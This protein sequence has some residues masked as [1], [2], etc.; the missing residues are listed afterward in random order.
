MVCRYGVQDIIAFTA[1]RFFPSLATPAILTYMYNVVPQGK[2]AGVPQML[3]AGPFHIG[4]QTGVV[5]LALRDKKVSQT[6]F[7]WQEKN[8]KPFGQQL[9][10]QCGRCG[11]VYAWEEAHASGEC[12][13]VMYSK[14]GQRRPCGNIWTANPVS[15]TKE[16]KGETGEWRSLVLSQG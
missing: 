11:S 13:G 5:H 12:Q 16:V 7:F 3:N 9:P 8:T 4:Q 10:A 15:D 2:E 1:P 14:F 6:R